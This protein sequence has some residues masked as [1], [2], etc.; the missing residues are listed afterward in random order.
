MTVTILNHKN[1]TMSQNDVTLVRAYLIYSLNMYIY[2]LQSNKYLRCYIVCSF[3]YMSKEILSLVLRSVIPKIK[4]RD[5][6]R[7]MSKDEN[8]SKCTI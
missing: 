8:N 1:I 4:N 5:N 7:A 2:S 6:C 3:Y